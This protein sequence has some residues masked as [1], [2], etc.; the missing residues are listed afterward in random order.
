MPAAGRPKG[1]VLKIRQ[2]CGNAVLLVLARLGRL[3]AEL[4]IGNLPDLCND[5]PTM[6]DWID[7]K[8]R[9][10]RNGQQ[11]ERQR[12]DSQLHKARIVE[13]KGRDVL[14]ALVNVVRRDVDRYKE[15]FKSD[16]DR[17]VDFSEKP[18]G[19]FEVYKSVF[20]SASVKCT[21][22]LPAQAIVAHYA[23][24]RDHSTPP[25]ERWQR[26]EL[27][28]DAADNIELRS[29]RRHFSNLD[30]VSRFLLEPVLFPSGTG[31]VGL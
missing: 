18:S 21:L 17:R 13:V 22:D 10:L 28:V 19:E 7:D 1:R 5:R 23:F 8:E 3:E 15:K 2:P 4:R 24:T 6:A 26:I 12:A 11:V 14:D 29:E 9:E 27:R 16:L 20:P 25:R 31:A 30:E